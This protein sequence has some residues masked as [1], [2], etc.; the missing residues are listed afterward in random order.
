LI[1]FYV[2]APTVG[3]LRRP[4]FSTNVPLEVI[5]Q[6]MGDV[7]ERFQILLMAE[8]DM[9][10]RIE[11]ARQIE[12]TVAR[13]QSERWQRRLARVSRGELSGQRERAPLRMVGIS[14]AD[15]ERIR[16]ESECTGDWRPEVWADELGVDV[17][18]LLYALAY[19]YSAA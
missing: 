15:L 4:N 5:A 13:M 8:I 6:T 7:L 10:I 3:E 2:G 1:L 17:D 12:T 11:V 19:R 16:R 9:R 18:D 14:D